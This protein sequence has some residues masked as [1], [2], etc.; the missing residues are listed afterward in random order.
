MASP[1]TALA[2]QPAYSPPP[3]DGDFYRIAHV[4]NGEER[5]LIKRVRAFAESVVAP[6]IDE[7]WARDEFPFEIIRK[8]RRSVSAG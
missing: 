3:I 5:A 7:Y 6:V 8:W 4:L 1:Q 2:E